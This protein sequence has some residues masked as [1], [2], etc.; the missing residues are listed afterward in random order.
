MLLLL[1]ADEKFEAI[2]GCAMHPLFAIAG[3]LLCL[4]AS[5]ADEQGVIEDSEAIQYV[6]KYIEVRG[7]VVSV[8]ASPLG[9]AYISFG[10]EFNQTFAGFIAADSEMSI[11][12]RITKLQGK[13]IGIIG[14]IE[15]RR[16]SVGMLPI[17][18]SA[19]QG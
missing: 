4:I 1:Q 3:L 10:R 18:Q 17:E 8:T 12:Q 14:T 2:F 15:L 13:I 19:R 6:G 9:T 5:R 11:D 7:L 16:G